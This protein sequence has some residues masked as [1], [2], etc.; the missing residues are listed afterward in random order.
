MQ[1]ELKLEMD[2][3]LGGAYPAQFQSVRM[4]LDDSEAKRGVGESGAQ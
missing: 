4:W 2:L 3:D 1:N